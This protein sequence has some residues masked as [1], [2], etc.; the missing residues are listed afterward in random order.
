MARLLD[1]WLWAGLVIYVLYGAFADVLNAPDDIPQIEA[2]DIL[3]LPRG[4]PVVSLEGPSHRRGANY[5]GTGFAVGDTNDWLTA[6]H[7]TANCRQLQFRATGSEQPRDEL[8]SGNVLHAGADLARLDA[9]H[10]DT[11]SL[12][13]LD[14]YD[15]DPPL[16]A[17]GHGY[18]QGI[19]A[20]VPV[21]FLSD[22]QVDDRHSGSALGAIWNVEAYPALPV[23]HDLGGMSGGPLIDP[24]S[25]V[26]GIVVGSAPRRARLVT[27][28]PV[29]ALSLSDAQADS[30]LPPLSTLSI[31]EKDR[32]LKRQGIIRLID[33]QS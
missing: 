1:R 5:I 18:P 4:L 9:P 21:T 3:S 19:S 32:Y 27:I 33:C 22:I 17:S 14:R 16:R 31:N 13:I 23:A 30:I 24:N 20:F 29:H 7:V 8:V 25:V 6:R 28:D 26:R 15:A 12:A 2:G 11:G 10:P